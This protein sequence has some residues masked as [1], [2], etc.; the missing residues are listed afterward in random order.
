MSEFMVLVLGVIGVI[1][2]AVA[3]VVSIKRSA[4]KAERMQSA[5]EAAE[6]VLKSTKEQLQAERTVNKE[7]QDVQAEVL[8]STD[9][10]VR[11]RL[12]RWTK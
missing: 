1:S 12:Q 4:A 10:A 11:A 9:S 7:V 2:A 8:S 5:K 6:A 3:G